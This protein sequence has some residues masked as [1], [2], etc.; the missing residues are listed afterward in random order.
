M[1]HCHGIGVGKRVADRFSFAA[2]STSN[3]SITVKYVFVSAGIP[4]DLHHPDICFH[5]TATPET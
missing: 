5:A 1:F 2:G 4:S 3:S